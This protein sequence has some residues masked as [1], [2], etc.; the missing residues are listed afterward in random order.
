MIKK[1]I[2]IFLL[3]NHHQIKNV[4]TFQKINVKKYDI[5]IKFEN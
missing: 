2:K 4:L 5:Y 1:S 3:Q